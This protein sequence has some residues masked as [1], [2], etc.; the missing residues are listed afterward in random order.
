MK[1]LIAR[2]CICILT[3]LFSIFDNSLII[4]PEENI[5][6][7][8]EPIEEQ[9]SME[10]NYP[11]AE[12]FAIDYE[13]GVITR[14]V[15]C[16]DAQIIM[17]NLVTTSQEIRIQ[18]FEI[19]FDEAQMMMKIA[20]AEAEGDGVKGKAMVM[21]VIL[22]RVKDDRFPDSIEE[23]IFQEYKGVYQFS[24]VEDG[25]YDKAE[26]DVECHLAL[27]EIERGEYDE[28]DA[29]YFENAGECWQSKNCEYIGTV[30]H[31]KFYK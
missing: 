8:F 19:T 30:G 25:R 6:L 16:Q 9:M 7:E 5:K 29:L 2:G 12:D 31:H 26:P 15:D 17:D 27:A 10:Y 13:T 21:A 23:V 18:G 20:M 24:P 22:N 3:A 1:R 4:Y 14:E 11:P 28:V